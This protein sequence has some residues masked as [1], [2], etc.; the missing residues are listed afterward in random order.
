MRALAIATIVSACAPSP[1][2][3]APRASSPATAQSP[4]ERVPMVGAAWRLGNSAALE[5]GVLELTCDR[6][7]P[8]YA[9]HPL[10]EL[11]HAGAW[12]ITVT[13]ANRGCDPILFVGVNAALEPSL[14]IAKAAVSRGQPTLSFATSGSYPLE[15]VLFAGS[16]DRCCGV[17][18]IS[19][20][21]LAPAG[22]RASGG[23]RLEELR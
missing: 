20:L 4:R 8:G 3:P 19:E 16:T 2:G 7:R 23:K 9:I 14:A 5:H 17:V 6:A 15:L 22:V 13:I 21:T 10:E 1:P 11:D 18:E 12:T